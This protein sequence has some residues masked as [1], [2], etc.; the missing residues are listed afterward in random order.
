MEISISKY[1][2][3]LTVAPKGR[4]DAI[5]APELE[6]KLEAKIDGIENL[7]FDFTELTYIS[8][9]GLRVLMIYIQLLEEQGSVVIKNVCKE[10]MDVFE[11]TG[12]TEFLD[13]K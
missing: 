1:K 7:I 4:L 8:S 6:E 5:T 3:K 10:V 9:A 12:L 2:N 11:V 13:I